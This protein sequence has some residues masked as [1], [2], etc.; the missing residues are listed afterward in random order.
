MAVITE[1]VCNND[2]T[3]SDRSHAG[4]VGIGVACAAL[5]A[6]NN[7]LIQV[8]HLLRITLQ[9]HIGNC[10]GVSVRCVAIGK[11][12][13]PFRSAEDSKANTGQFAVYQIVFRIQL[14]GS[15]CACGHGDSVGH[16][17]DIAFKAIR[18][19]THINSIA[20]ITQGGDQHV[21][22]DVGTGFCGRG[23]GN[24]RFGN[25]GLFHRIEYDLVTVVAITIGDNYNAVSHGCYA[26]AVGI[27]IASAVVAGG[28]GGIAHIEGT[29]FCAL[30]A[31]I[32]NLN[33]VSIRCVAVFQ[34]RIPSRSA[35]DSKANT[36]KLAVCHIL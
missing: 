3:V 26:C 21:Q 17:V 28:N 15:R 19:E 32:G 18:I 1:T 13:I 12:G 14:Y 27:G 33:C 11:L 20:G 10:N 9:T 5:A 30:Q 16:I 36:R 2:G 23:F 31:H 24:L 35:E 8:K 22:A 6:G 4:A 7:R 25:L 34:H 29:L